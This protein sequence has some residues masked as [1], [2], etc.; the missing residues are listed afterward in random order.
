VGAGI[1]RK[2]V[3]TAARRLGV[4][5]QSVE[6]RG[7]HE[8]EGAFSAM[9]RARSDAGIVI[10]DPVFF[11]ARTEMARLAARDRL[12]IMYGVSEHVEAGGLMS[13]GG[14]VAHQFRRAAVYVDKILKGAR[15]GDLAVEQAATFELVVNQKTAH[16][17]GITLPASLL[18]RADRIIE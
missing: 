2:A 12:P 6:V 5:L 9:A 10:P 11:S 3:E 17:L 4:T 16:A 14:H 8:L 13:Y 15:P 1:Y 18:L 7:R